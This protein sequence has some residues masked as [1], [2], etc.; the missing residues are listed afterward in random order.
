MYKVKNILSLLYLDGVYLQRDS[1]KYDARKAFGLLFLTI[2][3]AIG[4]ATILS[5]LVFVNHKPFY[6]HI[7]ILIASFGITFGV[8]S[9]KLRMVISSIGNRIKNSTSWTVGA[10]ALNGICW[11]VPFAAIAVFP[12]L[13]QYLILL[14]IGL[15]NFSTY[16]LMKK[17]SGLDNRE[18]MI[19]GLVSL[20]AIPI[21]V[22]IDTTLFITRQ[23][24]A[25]MF[26][27]ILISIA[28]GSGGIYG[29][30]AK[31]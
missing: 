6:Y 23:D 16:L 1:H 14:G 5:E 26:S 10:K 12:T 15:G 31:E 27:R 18:Q 4:A 8:I 30:T 17:Y 19:V 13:Y 22:E 9:S 24:I 3:I 7:I 2:S 29:L 25:V 20:I 11:A 21:V 28:Y